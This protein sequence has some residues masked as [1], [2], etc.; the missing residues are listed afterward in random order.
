MCHT[1]FGNHYGNLRCPLKSDMKN[2]LLGS[3]G[4]WSQQI[5][6]GSWVCEMNQQGGTAAMQG[7]AGSPCAPGAASE[8]SARQLLCLPERD[9]D[10]RRLLQHLGSEATCCYSAKYR[11]M[12]TLKSTERHP[13]QNC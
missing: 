11:N 12:S 7:T 6:S 3:K 5:S 4:E 13:P 2:L 8:Q 10:C 1:A 9:R